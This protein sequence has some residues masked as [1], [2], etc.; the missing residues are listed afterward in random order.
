MIVSPGWDR[1]ARVLEMLSGHAEPLGRERLGIS[2]DRSQG[3]KSPSEAWPFIGLKGAAKELGD[4]RTR[5]ESAIRS[6]GEDRGRAA[7]PIHGGEG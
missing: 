5:V 4:L 6:A 2:N 3:P 1:H 7:Q